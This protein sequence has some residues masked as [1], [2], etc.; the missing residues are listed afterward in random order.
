M[1]LMD[2]PTTTEPNDEIRTTDETRTTDVGPGEPRAID[3]EPGDRRAG[4]HT[5]LARPPSERYARDAA[6]EP[7]RRRSR[8]A[9]AFGIAVGGAAIIAFL[10]GPLSMTGGLLAV[11]AIVGLILGSMLRPATVLAASLAVGSVVVGLLAVWL[12]A[13]AEGGVLDPITYLADVQG[14]LA[15]ILLLV[16]ALAAVVGSR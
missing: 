3:V 9:Q 8:A 7:D 15:P 10:G 12:F 16:A 11:A 14:P 4:Q 5:Q 2:D 6:P 1:A 13:R